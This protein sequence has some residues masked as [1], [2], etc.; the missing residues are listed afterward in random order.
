MGS[1]VLDSSTS[2]DQLRNHL[3]GLME[4]SSVLG[5]FFHESID[6]KI[7]MSS[8]ASEHERVMALVEFSAWFCTSQGTTPGT[9]SNKLF[10]VKYF[11]VVEAGIEMMPTES[12]LL[13]RIMAC[14]KRAMLQAILPRSSRVLIT[15]DVL[16]AHEGRVALT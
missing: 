1:G 11:Q 2:E 15:L 14:K 9:V 5:S 12:P 10:T 6:A 16:L 13:K 4:L 3:D 7:C 8:K